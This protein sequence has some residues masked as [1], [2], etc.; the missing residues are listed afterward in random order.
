MIEDLSFL[1]SVAQLVQ[2]DTVD[3]GAYLPTVQ[4]FNVGPLKLQN[5][6]EYQDLERFINGYFDTL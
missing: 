6:P 2:I 3:I 1:T 4:Q 5:M